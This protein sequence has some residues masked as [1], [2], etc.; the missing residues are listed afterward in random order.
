LKD[1]K[2]YADDVG[3]IEFVIPRIT[4]IQ[5]L[6]SNYPTNNSIAYYRMSVFLPYLDSLISSLTFRFQKKK[7]NEDAVCI[8]SLHPKSLKKF[9]REEITEHINRIERFYGEFVDN[10][11]EEGL[12]WYNTWISQ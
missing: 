9:L 11:V 8:F 1:I 10:I 2:Q 7:K 4:S 6:R 5:T 3:D 12:V